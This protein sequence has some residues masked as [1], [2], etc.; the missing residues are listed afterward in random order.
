MTK[1]VS[2]EMDS[3]VGVLTLVA[4][5]AGLR[6]ILWPKERTGRVVFPED[7]TPGSHEILEVARTQ[8]REYL[9]LE[10]TE[11]DVPFDM[12]GTDFQIGVWLGLTK[13]PYGQT[14]TYGDLATDLDRPGAARAV[15][16]ATG[17]NP[18]SIIVPCHRL[19]GTNGKLTG[20]AGGLETKKWLLEHESASQRLL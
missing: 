11:F 7:P 20:F 6:A 18:L 2:T 8:L 12:V 9:A 15:G 1:L 17:R 16:A 13:I 10:R 19:V 5:S 14:R 3:P 4:S